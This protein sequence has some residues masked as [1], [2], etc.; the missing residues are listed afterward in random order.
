[1]KGEPWNAEHLLYYMVPRSRSPSLLND[2]S[3]YM[4]EW[5]AIARCHQSQM[6]IR[7]GK[8]L[9]FLRALRAA[10]GIM[11][12]VPYAEGFLSEE[13]IAFE[14]SLFMGKAGKT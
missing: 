14:L 13:P 6:S 11:L 10:N 12:G 7:D 3:A 4:E 1:M 2:V 5:E 8:V 9:E